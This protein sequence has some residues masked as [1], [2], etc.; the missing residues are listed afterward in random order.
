MIGS[1]NEMTSQL[2]NKGLDHSDAL[3]EQFG[4][5]TFLKILRVWGREKILNL[6]Q[7]EKLLAF[8]E[9]GINERRIINKIIKSKTV[10]HHFLADP[11]KYGENRGGRH[12]FCEPE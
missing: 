8:Y 11:Q 1:R 3:S 4:E 7:K 2:L 6:V 5:H 9:Y 12:Q 10:V